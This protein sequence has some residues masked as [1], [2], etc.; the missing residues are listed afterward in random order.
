[1]AAK[2]S[3]V[4]K[5]TV[6]KLTADVGPWVTRLLRLDAHAEVGRSLRDWSSFAAADVGV[7]TLVLGSIV[8]RSHPAREWNSAASASSVPDDPFH[9]SV[10]NEP[11]DR[12]RHV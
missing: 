12:N 7:V 3:R 5:K 11:H 6:Y 9:A 10:R 1:M 2:L 8:A 4:V